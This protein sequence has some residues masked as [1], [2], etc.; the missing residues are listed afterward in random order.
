[1][2]QLCSYRVETYTPPLPAS[3]VATLTDFWHRIFRTDESRLVPILNG[4]ECAENSDTLYAAWEDGEVACTVHLTVSR[5]DPRL[6]GLGEVATAEKHRG[7]GL[8]SEL[9]GRAALD[10]DSMGGEVLFLGTVNP[11]AARVYRRLGWMYYPGTRVMGRTREPV[12]PEKQLHRLFGAV[13]SERPVL[14]PMTPKDRIRIIPLILHP[15]RWIV[16]DMNVDLISTRFCTQ[17]SCMGLYPRFQSLSARGGKSWT[18]APS[19]AGPALGIASLIPVSP[20]VAQ[21]DAFTHPDSGASLPTLIGE[22]VRYAQAQNFVEIRANLVSHD[23]EKIECYRGM[24][25]REVNPGPEV[26][27]GEDTYRSICLRK[28]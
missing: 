22:P 4:M 24:G 20:S 21:V 16:L 5:T 6:G 25:F 17:F 14:R 8:A 2:G 18:L 9:C 12:A 1:M 10:F 15:H 28:R 27:I 23:F 7:R 3:L 26:A 19:G 11:N 13:G